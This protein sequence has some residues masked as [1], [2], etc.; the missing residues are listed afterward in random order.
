M[1]NEPVIIAP[2]IPEVAMSLVMVLLSIPNEAKPKMLSENMRKSI[3]S[4]SKLMGI[5]YPSADQILHP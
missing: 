2:V 1:T 5:I 3:M 4:F